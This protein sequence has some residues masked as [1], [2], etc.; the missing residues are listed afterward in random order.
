MAARENQNLQI[1]LIIFV[2]LTI[3]LSVTTFIFY[4]NYKE[5]RKLAED[6]KKTSDDTNEKMRTLQDERNTLAMKLGLPETDTKDQ[7]DNRVKEDFN[8][9]SEFFKPQSQLPPDQQNYRRLIDELAKTIDAKNKELAAAAQ[10]NEKARQDLAA[11]EA[12][13]KAARDQYEED[14]NKAVH[15]EQSNQES[16]VAQIAQL[17]NTV[18]QAQ[19]MAAAKEQALQTLRSQAESELKKLRDQLKQAQDTV[20]NKQGIIEGLTQAAPTVPDGRI[21]WVNQRD[22]TVYINVGSDDGLQRRISF[23]VYD[24]NA[25]DAAT[26]VKK[27]SIEVLNIRGPHLAEARIMETTNSDPI[28]PGDIIYT[29]IWQPGQIQH[30]AI[31]GFIDFDNDAASDRQKL[32]DLIIHNGGV[33]DAEV[34]ERGDVTGRLAYSTNYLILGKSPTEKDSEKLRNSFTS[35]SRE[36]TSYG[37]PTIKLDAFLQQIGYNARPVGASNAN[38]PSSMRAPTETPDRTST[39]GQGFRERRPPATTKGG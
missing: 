3:I 35:M 32:R 22:D 11:A 21:S 24:R 2:M 18:K 13:F 27:G 12:Q 37:V 25:T 34:D 1:A 38:G 28:V 7:I 14:K 23:N 39:S 29:P 15:T 9:Y 26:A 20:Q 5:Q 16:Y 10:E 17:S 36:A 30:F 8:K 33:I 6:A 31:A 19:G 4:N